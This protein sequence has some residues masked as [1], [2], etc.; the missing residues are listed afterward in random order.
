MHN[1]MSHSSSKRPKRKRPNNC[2][3]VYTFRFYLQLAFGK[4]LLQT[5][6]SCTKST[7]NLDIVICVRTRFHRSFIIVQRRFI[8]DVIKGFVFIIRQLCITWSAL[9]INLD[10]YLTRPRFVIPC[11]FPFSPK[12]SLF[13]YPSEIFS[14]FFSSH[15]RY[16]EI[17][18]ASAFLAG[19]GKRAYVAPKRLCK[20]L[21]WLVESH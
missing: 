16:N 5:S 4:P 9:W 12:P 18:K 14:F 1:G 7:I 13:P 3:S 15:Y 17:Q 21:Y 2:L 10:R 11:L 8:C 19:V 6:C 20:V